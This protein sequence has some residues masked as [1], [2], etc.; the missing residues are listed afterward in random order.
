MSES[1][2]PLWSTRW[3]DG[4]ELDALAHSSQWVMVQ[5]RRGQTPFVMTVAQWEILPTAEFGRK[6]KAEYDAALAKA[7]GQTAGT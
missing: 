7:R 3:F 5:H 6:Y 1:K 4:A 2:T